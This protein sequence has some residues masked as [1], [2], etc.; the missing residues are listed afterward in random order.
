MLNKVLIVDDDPLNLDL[1]EQELA[2]HYTIETARDGQEG[3]RKAESFLPDVIL[4]D[5]MMPK[6]SGIEVVKRLK[7]DP[8]FKGIPV[9]LV[10]AKGSREDKVEGLDAERMQGLES[11]PSGTLLAGL[12]AGGAVDRQRP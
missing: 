11:G 5:Y 9:I 4:L 7:Q 8:R 12:G 3:L 10:T 6:M 1:L 2:E